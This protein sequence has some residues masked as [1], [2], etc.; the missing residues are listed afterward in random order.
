MLTARIASS[1]A[2]PSY[3]KPVGPFLYVGTRSDDPNDVVPHE[4]RREL[5]ALRVFAAWTNHVDSKAINSL[6]ALVTENGKAVVR[7][8]L[9]DFGSTMGSASIKAREYDEGFEYIVDGKTTTE[10]HGR[11]GV[12]HSLVSLRR[13]SKVPVGRPFLRRSLRSTKLETSGSKPGVSTCAP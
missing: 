11:F 2:K 7:H 4:H 3:G 13:L 9:I 8:Y 12:L 5:R 10:E 6:D 1:R